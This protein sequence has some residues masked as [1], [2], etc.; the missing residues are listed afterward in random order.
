MN[1]DH[2]HYQEADDQPTQRDMSPVLRPSGNPSASSRIGTRLG[3]FTINR[4]I[5]SGGMGTVYKATQET[6]RR[7][8][9]LKVMKSGLAS[10]QALKRFQYEAEVLARL[11]HPCIA[12]VY[13]A[14]TDSHEEETPWFA[15]EFLVGAKPIT[16]YCR[17]KQLGLKEKLEL[18]GQICDGAHHGHQKGI[19]HRDLKPGNI[20]V[21]SQGNPKIIDFGVA[22]S[23]DSDIAIH[24][25]QTDVGELIGTLQYMSPE[26]CLADPH[27][28]DVRSDVYA[29][30]VMLYELLTNHMPYDV[31]GHP[32]HE[33]ARMVCEEQPARPSTIMRVIRG[34]IETICLKA[35]EKDRDRRYQSALDLQQDIRRFLEGEPITARR[36]TLTYQLKLLYKRHRAAGVLA[37]AFG[38]LLIAST[39]LLAW[40]A[41][42][43]AAALDES[44]RQ[45]LR[46]QAV[47]DGI[48]SLITPPVWNGVEWSTETT[49]KEVLDHGRETLDWDAIETI[50]SPMHALHVAYFR[51]VLA[52]GY[53]NCNAPTEALA[54][55]AGTT[56]ELSKWFKP[57]DPELLDAR[58]TEANTMAA[59]GR[60]QEAAMIG[61]EVLEIKQQ[62]LG[63][64]SHDTLGTAWNV[65]VM[66]AD[67]GDPEQ[68]RQI[69]EQSLGD[70][71]LIQNEK[72]GSFKQI[73]DL[74]F[75]LNMLPLEQRSPWMDDLFNL[76]IEDDS[77]GSLE[78]LLD[79]LNGEALSTPRTKAALTTLDEV[80]DTILAY[81]DNSEIA[82]QWRILRSLTL[83]GGDRLEEAAD[84]LKRQAEID[85]RMPG[86]DAASR[87][88]L[89]SILE[90][91]HE[92]MGFTETDS[93]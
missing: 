50:D 21:T 2:D 91:I 27:D 81:G 17:D 80:R 48:T 71:A 86:L 70:V 67:S 74:V 23:T 33:A 8:V 93:P 10:P 82:R 24:T 46:S 85:E 35:L 40:L 47:I 55:A 65:A 38:L 57:D 3:Q 45:A 14:G 84:L 28:I 34:D 64:H 78:M 60:V 26:Q 88:S 68:A 76:L 49:W 69:C 6:P 37:I 72:R 79:L 36:P 62:K 73:Q 19:I 15:M 4:V 12:Q 58:L 9:A 51:L 89:Q 13:E 39:S 43:Q 56:A 66:I 92:R 63:L 30:G 61:R 25:L 7:T 29:L 22:R 90:R 5:G 42:T 53:L 41:T 44:R 52:N 20:L 87:Q 16:Q 54:V 77:E 75:L 59:N 1:D 32:M 18:F 11:R 31:S 83:E